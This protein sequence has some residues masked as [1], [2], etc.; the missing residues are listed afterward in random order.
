MDGATPSHRLS[1]DT[2]IY[3][4]RGET[5]TPLTGQRRSILCINIKIKLYVPHIDVLITII[6]HP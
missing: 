6:V 3:S 4:L 1:K 5:K 2:E